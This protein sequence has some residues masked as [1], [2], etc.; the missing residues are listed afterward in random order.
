VGNARLPRRGSGGRSS[1]SSLL[2]KC[3]ELAPNIAPTAVAPPFL[4][5]VFLN[6][7]LSATEAL[8]T[9]SPTTL[10]PSPAAV[11]LASL[12]VQHRAALQAGRSLT[13]KIA[14]GAVA[15]SNTPKIAGGTAALA[16]QA[17]PR[18]Q[19]RCRCC[20]TPVVG[21]LAR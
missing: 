8:V 3:S 16:S 18:P 10:A 7:H 1:L 2:E 9:A 5:P 11:P 19:S 20:S 6:V 4:V 14:A 15:A 17:P 13:F 12:I 21:I